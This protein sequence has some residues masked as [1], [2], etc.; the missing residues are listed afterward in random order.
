MIQTAGV[1]SGPLPLALRIASLFAGGR[2]RNLRQAAA[3]SGIIGSLCLRYG[4][5]AAG[6]VS[7]RDWKTPLKIPAHEQLELSTELIEKY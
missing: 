1:L 3:L 4:W 6:R 7:A 2:K 5:V